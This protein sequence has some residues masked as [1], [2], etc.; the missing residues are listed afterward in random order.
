MTDRSRTSRSGTWIAIAMTVAACGTSAAE[1]RPTEG[2][3]E[4]E[5]AEVAPTDLPTLDPSSVCGR[6]RA[7]CE[8]YAE[9]VPNV[10]V[11]SACAGPGEVAADPDSDARCRAMIAGWRE[12]LRLLPEVDPPPACDP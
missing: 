1:P 3:Q 5:P 6:A 2:A 7:C 11:D 10:V 8:A 4:S 12:T 9:A